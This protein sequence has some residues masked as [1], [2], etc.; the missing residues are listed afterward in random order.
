LLG[1]LGRRVEERVLGVEGADALEGVGGEPLLGVPGR[2]LELLGESG[3]LDA[4]GLLGLSG[5]G[6]FE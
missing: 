1:E 2:V 3:F 6:L 4:P 5:G